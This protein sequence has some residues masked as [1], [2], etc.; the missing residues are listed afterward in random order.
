MADE[1]LRNSS[2]SNLQPLVS[3]F[4]TVGRPLWSPYGLSKCQHFDVTQLRLCGVGKVKE[5]I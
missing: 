5:W 3:R 2:L 4:Q 1:F